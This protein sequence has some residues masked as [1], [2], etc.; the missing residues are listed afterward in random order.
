MWLTDSAWGKCCSS[1][2]LIWRRKGVTD[3][4]D[5][6][7]ETIRSLLLQSWGLPADDIQYHDEIVV[8]K[9]GHVCSQDVGLH[10]QL[11]I[12][13]GGGNQRVRAIC[14]R[15][16][17]NGVKTWKISGWN[18][19]LKKKKRVGETAV[20]NETGRQESRLLSNLPDPSEPVLQLLLYVAAVHHQL[21]RLC[22]CSIIY[23]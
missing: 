2:W 7:V 12:L 19:F 22:C 17:L 3:N 15:K 4:E 5:Q 10:F 20:F 21:I 8:F 11:D 13:W 16:T 18:W 23:R 1:T 14:G 6:L 9:V